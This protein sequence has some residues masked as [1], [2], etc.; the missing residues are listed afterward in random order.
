MRIEPSRHAF[1]ASAPTDKA[2][3]R[4]DGEPARERKVEAAVPVAP[5]Q[6]RPTHQPRGA[7]APLIAQL[8]AT[9]LEMPQTRARRRAAPEVATGAYGA[10][11]AA[12]AAV[13]PAGRF[14][15]SV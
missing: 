8:I 13:E 5:A 10:C 4:R 2:G 12:P 1:D 6:E 9:R 15:R 3:R 14:R 11:G 7:Y